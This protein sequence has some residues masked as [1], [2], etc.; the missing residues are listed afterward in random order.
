MFT[1]FVDSEM[2]R[3]TIARGRKYSFY[4]FRYLHPHDVFVNGRE[5]TRIARKRW[6]RARA[7][8]VRVCGKEEAC[9]SMEG[10]VTEE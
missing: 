3:H 8:Y 2:K 6:K 7:K 10:K 1:A 4:R 5:G 9:E